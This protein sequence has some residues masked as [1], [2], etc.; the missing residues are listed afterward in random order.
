MWNHLIDA[1]LLQFIDTLWNPETKITES[2]QS[3]T[4]LCYPLQ[5]WMC[6]ELYKILIKIFIPFWPLVVE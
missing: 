3:L 6:S 2:L 1:F 4:L 5:H